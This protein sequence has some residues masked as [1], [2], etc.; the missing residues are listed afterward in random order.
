MGLE[1]G[2][3]ERERKENKDGVNLDLWRARH[4]WKA[5][6]GS[7]EGLVGDWSAGGEDGK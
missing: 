7:K 6:K 3:I 5:Y 1:G 4:M 2:A